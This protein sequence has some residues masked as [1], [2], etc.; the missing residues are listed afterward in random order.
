MKK[1][2][3]FIIVLIIILFNPLFLFAHGEDKA[4]PNGGFIRMPGAYHTELIPDGKNKLKVYLLDLQWKN[5]S[6][7]KSKVSISY[8]GKSKETATCKPE[9][10]FYLCSFPESVDLTAKGN[11]KVSSQREGQEGM[12]VSYPLPLKLE[13]PATKPEGHGSH[14]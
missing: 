12:E 11:L 5:P 2:Y 9:Q 6:L 8:S 3:S 10:N 4:G 14:H 7:M 13:I 1:N